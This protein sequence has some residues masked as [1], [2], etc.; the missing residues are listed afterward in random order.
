MDSKGLLARLLPS[1]HL[2]VKPNLSEIFVGTMVSM[3]LLRLLSIA[4]LLSYV[5]C[6]G[7]GKG[8]P[9]E[10]MAVPVI[11]GKVESRNIRDEITVV[12][13]LA[14]DESVRIQSEMQGYVAEVQFDEGQKVAQGDVLL[15]I[16]QDKRAA[17]LAEIKAN[18]KLASAN[19][20]RDKELL[21]KG[22]ISS[23]EYDQSLSAFQSSKAAVERLRQELGD[24]TIRAPFAGI[25]GA[26]K[27]S[28]GQ[29]IGM[30]E[31]LTTLVKS[32]IMKAEFKIPERY[33]SSLAV[34]QKISISV[35][36]YADKQFPGEV[37]FIDPS[38][39]VVTRTVFVKAKLDNPD[40]ILRPGML[41]R[42]KL[43]T[44][45]RLAL[46]IPETAIVLDKSGPKVF[47]V[48]EDSTVALNSVRLGK[49]MAGE[50]EVVEGLT[51]E[52]TVVSEGT[53]KL[54]PGA[55][56]KVSQSKPKGN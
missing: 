3:N 12:G 26:R 25:V 49:R 36:A 4:M 14:A 28:P 19:L 33:L 47:V 21:A 20:K 52:A 15:T 55:L 45:E 54:R 9:P 10:G 24:A 18:F 56:V 11:A 42:V 5:S 7:G 48:Q 38:V 53:Q 34:G 50:V 37:F 41:A 23:K 22:T 1:N 30:G 51:A 27:V 46:V 40:G 31:T 13:D 43:V 35:S 29:M 39:D 17:S 6:G 2:R 32:D 44:D 16:N 8:G